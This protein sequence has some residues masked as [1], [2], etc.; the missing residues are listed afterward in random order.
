MMKKE[1]RLQAEKMYLNAKGKITNREIAKALNVNAL[2][3]GRWKREDDWDATLKVKEQAVTKEERAGFVRKKEAREKAVKLYMEAGGNITNKELAKKV[4]VSPAT[5]SKWKEVDAWI[6]QIQLGPIEAEESRVDQE[7]SGFDL[8]ELASPEHIL[9]INR[10]IESLLIREHLT[11]SEI[12]D[13][14]SAKST[15]LEAIVTYLVIV[16]DVTEM[17]T[18]R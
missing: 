4:E 3:V 17:K 13:L 10:K 16:R 1:A 6:T 8:G 18:T 7:D 9:E 12:L 2:T 15:L 11:A 5:I 14:A